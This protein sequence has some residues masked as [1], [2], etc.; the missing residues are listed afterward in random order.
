[1]EEHQATPGTGTGRKAPLWV[2]PFLRALERTGEARAA[3]E[4]AGIDYTTA[5]ARRRAHA[6]FAAAW[7]E[8]LA[9][10]GEAKRLAE[11]AEIAAVKAANPLTRLASGESD[12]SPQ[13]RGEVVVSAGKVR[14]AGRGR[15]SKEKEKIF[16]DELAATSNMA[17]AAKAAGVST[18]A[19]LARRLK[20]RLFAAKFEAVVQSA[21]AV[22]DLYL[23]EE[24]KKSFNPDD[25]D[26]GDVR[27]RVTIDQAIKISQRNAAKARQD[28]EADPF[29]EGT[30]MDDDGLDAV[31]ES[32]LGKLR[33]IREA[34]RREQ[35]ALGWTLDESFD[36]MIPPGY[37]KGP[38]YRPLP[39]ELPKDYYS[40]YR[41][42]G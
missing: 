1:V 41:M 34:D 33:R 39:P 18:N 9:A 3:A 40:N 32:I 7:V 42:G 11:E 25:L 36:V 13:R 10:H 38:D 12:L 30:A 37:V 16:F 19:I 17:M 26:T 14:R 4:D 21:K 2:V 29:A 22:I 28:A 8:A 31:K 20:H 35:L 24:A 27:P 15:W 23:I 5:Y 6:D